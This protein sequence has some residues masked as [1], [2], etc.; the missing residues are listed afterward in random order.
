MSYREYNEHVKV[1]A[2]E[3][4]ERVNDEGADQH[5]ALHEVVDGSEY[6]I[7][8]GKQ[9]EVLEHTE[10]L[11]YIEDMGVPIPQSP[12][13]AIQTIA[14]YALMGDVEKTLEEINQ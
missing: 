13:D 2:Q 14:F 11:Y 5:E 3:I 8:H 6:V 4:F 10:D 12:Q 7:Y 1:L 9:L